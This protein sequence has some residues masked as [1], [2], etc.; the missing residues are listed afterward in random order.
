MRRGAAVEIPG[1]RW[2]PAAP[3]SVWNRICGTRAGRTWSA[4]RPI[5]ELHE[6]RTTGT[7]VTDWRGAAAQRHRA[8]VAGGARPSCTSGWRCSR[9]RRSATARRS[10]A[11][12]R[13]RRRSATPRRCCWRSMRSVHIAGPSGRRTV[14]LASFFTG[15][16]KTALG[17]DEMLTAIEIPKPF[18]ERCASTRWPSGASTTSARSPRPWR[19]IATRPARRAARGSPSA[20]WPPRRCACATPRT[21]VIG[22]P[23]NESSV[24]RVQRV[25]DRTLTPDERSPRVERIPTRGVEEP[26]REVLDG[27]GRS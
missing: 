11:T 2:W 12:W 23:W 5:D 15:Y 19:S 16:R 4:W 24:E 13:P 25:L 27:V 8:A 22:Q 10:A 26:G 3:T 7:S 21:R 14:P 18:P 9:R 6:S 1:R 17:P 20:A